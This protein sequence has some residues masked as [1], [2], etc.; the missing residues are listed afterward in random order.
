MD[1]VEFNFNDISVTP[2]NSYYIV[3]KTTDGNTFNGYRWGFHYN[4]PYTRGS[5]YRTINAGVTWSEYYYYDFC[6]KTY[7]V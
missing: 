4:T 3:V 6:F 7:G 5:F 1:W 2:E